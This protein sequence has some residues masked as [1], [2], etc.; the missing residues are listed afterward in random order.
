MLTAT[1]PFLLS[2]PLG[3]GVQAARFL[4]P[5]LRRQLDGARVEDCALYKEMATEVLAGISNAETLI[6]NFG[7]VE[8]F[9]TAFYQLLLKVRE[10]LRA[11]N[12]RLL[13][14]GFS[15]EITEGLS[16]LQAERI[17]EI[18]HTEEQAWY[19]AQVH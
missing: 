18:T 2:V 9:P 19:K 3:P 5:D 17:F 1:G 7:L 10:E 8:R 16:V 15:P 14:C 11:K 13:L 12:A 4:H 6:L